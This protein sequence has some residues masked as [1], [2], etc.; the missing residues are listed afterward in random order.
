MLARR[1]AFLPLTKKPLFAGIFLLALTFVGL[2]PVDLKASE[3]SILNEQ[4][5]LW[6]VEKEGLP[7]GHLFGTIHITDDRVRQLAEPVQDAFDQ[8]DVAVFEVLLDEASQI[9]VAQTMMMHDG[10]TLDQIM[11]PDDYN[12]AVIAASELGVP[13][14]AVRLFKPWALM[15]LLIFPKEEFLRKAQ[16]HLPLDQ[17]LT[18]RAKT[19][20]K[21]VVAL[22]TVDEQLG[23]FDSM[24]QGD[25][26]AMLSSVVNDLDA[27]QALYSSMVDAYLAGNVGG[28]Y[29][30]TLERSAQSDPRL[31]REFEEKIVIDR[32]HRMAQRLEPLLATGKVFAAVGAA[33]LPGEEGLVELL[34]NRGYTVTKVQ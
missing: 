16:G 23:L 28:I 33:H 25:Q 11:D 30:Q 20:G 12:K 6:R 5:L 24:L 3:D 18:E 2:G 31:T 34:K 21:E 7:I 27:A 22:E 29:Q 26:V 17:D 32:N 8:A 15:S 13:E 10:R 19:A 9:R 1:F 14:Q 4:G